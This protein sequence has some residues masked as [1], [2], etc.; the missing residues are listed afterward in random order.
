MAAELAKPFPGWD[1]PR[2]L[3][4]YECFRQAFC[5][6]AGL[7]PIRVNFIDP[8]DYT[9]NFYSEWEREFARH[10][11]RF[12]RAS[13]DEAERSG[14][15]W[16]A[17]VPSLRYGATTTHAVTML[18][19]KLVRDSAASPYRRSQRPKKFCANPVIPVPRGA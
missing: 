2:C 3:V 19:S 16:I 8:T 17:I 10:G 6:A 4:P 9:I 7:H 14:L 5:C 18:G 11:F 12:Q 1:P 13:L 15:H